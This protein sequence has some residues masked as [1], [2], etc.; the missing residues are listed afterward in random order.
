[1]RKDGTLSGTYAEGLEAPDT[2]VSTYSNGKNKVGKA[3]LTGEEFNA[4]RAKYG[5]KKQSF[6]LNE[7]AG[8][9]ESVLEDM[10]KN[11][12]KKKY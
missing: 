6:T 9:I 11:K 10:K 5:S 8:L 4:L 1:M 7:R 12:G 2:F 3:D